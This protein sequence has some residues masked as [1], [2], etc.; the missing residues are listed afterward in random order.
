MPPLITRS[1]AFAPDLLFLNGL[2]NKTIIFYIWYSSNVA[3]LTKGENVIK[4]NMRLKH[5][6]NINTRI[7]SQPWLRKIFPSSRRNRQDR[8]F[9]NYLKKSRPTSNRPIRNRREAGSFPRREYSLQRKASTP[10]R[11]ELSLW[12]LQSILRWWITTSVTRRH[13]INGL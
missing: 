6:F 1:D 9:K 10:P 5:T 12:M 8:H 11:S 4:L 3:H 2:E 13:S 7:I